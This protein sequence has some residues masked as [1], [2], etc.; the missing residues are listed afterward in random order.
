MNTLNMYEIHQKCTCFVQ[1]HTRLFTAHSS[2]METRL[3]GS[4]ILICYK[5]G[6][7]GHRT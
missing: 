7:H 1:Y 4:S 5:T 3:T 6:L 2:L